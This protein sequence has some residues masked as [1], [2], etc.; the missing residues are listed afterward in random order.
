MSVTPAKLY[1]GT[2]GAG[3]AVVYTA[4]AGGM[5]VALIVAS[6]GTGG[7]QPITIAVGGTVIWGGKSVPAND[8]V[9]MAGPLHMAAGD[10]ISVASPS[11]ALTL[12]LHGFAVA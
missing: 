1:E 6:N 2:P 10:T 8:F 4:P 9:R 11:G 12:H 5:E 7:A 3:P